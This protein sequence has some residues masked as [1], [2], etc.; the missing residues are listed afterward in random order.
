MGSILRSL[1]TL[2]DNESYDIGRLLWAVGLVV[3]VICALLDVYFKKSFDY[4]NYGLTFSAIMG[5]G[6][7]S[8]RLKLPTECKETHVDAK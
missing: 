8:L 5:A 7:G 1:L 2:A 3:F 6:A 4:I